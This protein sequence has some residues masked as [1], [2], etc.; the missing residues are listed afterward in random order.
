MSK[1]ACPTA[2]SLGFLSFDIDFLV[3]AYPGGIRFGQVYAEGGHLF[4]KTHPFEISQ[5][6]YSDFSHL[7][8]NISQNISQNT[9][10]AA[11][12]VSKTKMVVKEY[13]ISSKVS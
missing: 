8:D 5:R 12:D 13:T 10:A 4:F 3:A 11:E 9:G 7:L 6:K 1:N 2:S